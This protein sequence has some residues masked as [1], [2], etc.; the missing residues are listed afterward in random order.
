MGG[1]LLRAFPLTCRTAGVDSGEEAHLRPVL[2]ADPGDVALVQQGCADSALR[3]GED[4]L[5]CFIAV[6][7]P[8]SRI[9]PV[10]GEDVRTK[11]PDHLVVV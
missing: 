5:Q 10:G 8:G 4:A 3:A 7:Q 11:V 9:G 1:G 2:I 6:R